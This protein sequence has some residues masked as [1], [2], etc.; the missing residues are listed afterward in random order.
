[1]T[2]FDVLL[3]GGQVVGPAHVACADLAISDGLIAEVGAE[4]EGSAALE[5]DASGLVLLPGG[6]DPHVHLN[7]PGTDWEGFSS[8]TAAFAAGGGTCLFDMPLNASPPTL[9][10]ASF[11]LKVETANGRA[12]TDF[13]L[14]G[15]LVPGDVDRLDELAERGVIGF[16]AFMCDTGMG[17]FPGADDL[18]LF[19]GMARAA[20]LG[21]PVAVHAESDAITA[22]LTERARREGRTTMRD[23]LDSRPA[24][25]ELE[26]VSRAIL[27][28]EETGCS[29][30]VV[31]VSTA[32]AA[33]LVAEARA[34]GVDVSC[35]TCPQY[36]LLTDADAERIGA[37][38]KC[39]PPI[40]SRDEVEAL[41]AEVLA[42]G[43]PMIAS[44]HSPA[45][46]ALK[47]GADAFAWWGGI[48]GVQTLRGTVAAAATERG[49]APWDIARLTAGA[50]A[51]RFSLASKGRLEVG[52]DA[53]LALIDLDHKGRVQETDLLYRYPQGAFAGCPVRGRNVRTLLRGNTVIDD[54]RLVVDATFGR[55]VRPSS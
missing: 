9:D 34:R 27:L 17:E 29:L 5:I 42:G 7:D 39:S 35:E 43:I 36:L 48:S 40:R 20:R 46:P 50:A 49:L 38:A 13:C 16:K 8:G 6:V 37:L 44:D 21:L 3:R 14:W 25:A 41:W 32:A 33:V 54:G 55:I 53:D 19:E 10:G 22:G 24:V 18:T 11:D 1:M 51:D 12:Y 23:Y 26:A 47:H 30:H 4:I 45:P 31:H 28:A 15:G 2:D 52:R